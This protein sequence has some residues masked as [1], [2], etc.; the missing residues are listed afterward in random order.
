MQDLN[1]LVGKDVD[2]TTMHEHKYLGDSEVRML[3]DGKIKKVNKDS[4][5]INSNK[6][7]AS[8]TVKKNEIYR[9]TDRRGLLESDVTLYLNKE[10]ILK[11]KKQVETL[12]KHSK[13]LY[14]NGGNEK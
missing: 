4:I 12:G 6:H 10:D 1:K 11:R 9:I 13:Q 14:E 7:P 8:I 5:T 2:I 3:R